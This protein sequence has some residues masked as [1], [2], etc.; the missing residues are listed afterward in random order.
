MVD[1]V[2]F[3][4]N[5]FNETALK[6]SLNKCGGVY[7]LGYEGEFWFGIHAIMNMI[8]VAFIIALLIIKCIRIPSAYWGRYIFTAAGL[9]VIIAFK[10][11]FIM[12]AVDL[13]FDIS[14]FLYALMGTMVYWNTFWYSKKNMLTVTHE[15]IIEHMQIPVVLF[16]YEGILADFNSS[17]KDVAGNLEYDNREQNIEWFVRENDLPV[18]PG[19]DTF[20]WKHNDRIYD[21]RIERLSDEKNRL[22]GTIIV[23][24]DVSELK[25]A[26]A[27]LENMVIYDQLTGVYS[28]YSFMEH[29]KQYDEYNGSVAVVVCDINHLSDINIQYGQKAGN[30]ALIN[31]AGVLKKILM[32]RAYIAR[33]NEGDFVAVMKN[34]TD[35]EADKTFEQIKRTVEK[36][37]NNGKL[38][39]TIEYGIAMRKASNRWIMDIVH[40]AVNDMRRQE[41]QIIHMKFDG[42]KKVD[43]GR[44]ISRYD[45][46]YTT[47]DDKKK[48]YEIISR[49]KDI[50]TLEDIRNEKTDGVVIVATDE[51]DEHIL[52]NKEYRMSVGDYVY[53]F[54]AGLIDEGETPE[55]A[56]KRELKE[57]TGLDLIVIEDKLYDSYSA[58]GF[59]NETNAVVIG[60]ASGDFSPSTSTFEEISAAWYS[61][62]EVKELLKDNH[63]AARTQAFCYMWARNK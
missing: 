21:C 52:I 36:E 43:E 16:D 57:E 1:S 26:Y 10:Y 9:I 51:A 56:A 46:Y 55:V 4:I 59:S 15:M 40:E 23:M 41:R 17:M 37:C 63:F 27:E 8:I 22:L 44:F 34:V 49:N 20:E 48:V 38:G 13:R 42:V 18:K 45:L 28:M 7:V 39:V 54:P 11:I 5:I 19:E 25:K 47:E 60:K 53:N 12:K 32:D 3:I 61:K 14:I 31:V 62:Q 24:Q 35:A 6:Y 58:I 29:C 33:I 30:Q 2:V 50:K